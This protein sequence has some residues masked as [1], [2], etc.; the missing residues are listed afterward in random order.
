MTYQTDGVII[1]C[2]DNTNENHYQ[3][4]FGDGRQMLVFRLES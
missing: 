2:N 3:L 1:S 4:S